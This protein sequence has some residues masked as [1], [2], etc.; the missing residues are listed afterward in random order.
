MEDF[1][2]DMTG[3]LQPGLAGVPLQRITVVE[4]FEHPDD[5]RPLN[6]PIQPPPIHQP[7]PHL[8]TLNV[9]LIRFG[10]FLLE[11]LNQLNGRILPQMTIKQPKQTCEDFIE[12]D[13]F[14]GCL[15]VNQKG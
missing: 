7:L 10:I 12:V 1:A 2:D 3:L 11:F 5:P 15:R 13:L 14:D 8:T 9:L 4:A 6:L